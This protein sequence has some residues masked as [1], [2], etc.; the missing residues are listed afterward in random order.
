MRYGGAV[1]SLRRRSRLPAVEEGDHGVVVL[2]APAQRGRLGTS[3]DHAC[4]ID[5]YLLDLPVALEDFLHL[6][7]GRPR[8]QP[9][10]KQCGDAARSNRRTVV[11]V[12]ET[13]LRAGRRVGLGAAVVP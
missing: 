2:P 3:A 13:Q 10:H 1:E 11:V 5:V 6:G 7:L 4:T 8:V 12:V 9:A